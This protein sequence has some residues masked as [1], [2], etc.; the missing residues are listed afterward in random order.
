MS[1]PQQQPLGL[2]RNARWRT[3]YALSIWLMWKNEKCIFTLK[4]AWSMST[5]EN[6]CFCWEGASTLHLSTWQSLDLSKVVHA[7]CL[8]WSCLRD[9]RLSFP[10]HERFLPKTDQASSSFSSISSENRRMMHSAK[11]HV[12]KRDIILRFFVT[13]HPRLLWSLD[14]TIQITNIFSW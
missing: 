12:P 5:S 13:C 2:R 7:V 9:N 4:M 11:L 1:D 6:F 10:E 3:S 14:T 8:L